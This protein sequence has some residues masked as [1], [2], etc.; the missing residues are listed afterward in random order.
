MR[1]S[2][3]WSVNVGHFAGVRIRLHAFFL[4]FGVLT[5]YFSTQSTSPMPWVGVASLAILLASVILHEI[6]HC[7]AAMRFG[8]RVDEIVLGPLGGLAPMYL[9]SQPQHHLACA[10]AG[11]VANLLVM[12]VAA[13]A[14]IWQEA[15]VIGLLHPF[16]PANLLQGP[17]WQVGL[18]LA[19]WINWMLALVNLLPADPMDCARILRSL[20]WPVFGYRRAVHVAATVAKVTAVMLCVAAWF[21]NSS[22]VAP[23]PAWVPLVLLAIV[24]FFS[25]KSEVQKFEE[26]EMND[27]WLGYDFSEGY[28]SLERSEK[29]RAEPPEPGPFRRWLEQR[30]QQRERHKQMIEEEE[31]WRVDDILSRV[32]RHGIDSISTE[33]QAILDRVSARYRH[34]E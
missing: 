24:L 17:A 25:A 33:D 15:S 30:R 28:T 20:L 8:G 14:L 13:P 2:S 29:L 3:I 34:R 22:D 27:K 7:Y 6:G 12:I 11:P 19:F 9:P 31:E 4:L 5:I 23:I 32:H 18:Q 21:T 1:S 26:R 10:A 16:A